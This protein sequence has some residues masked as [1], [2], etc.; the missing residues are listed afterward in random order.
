MGTSAQ[1]TKDKTLAIPKAV[2]FHIRESFRI[3]GCA[4]SP[5]I[6]T[7]KYSWLCFYAHGIQ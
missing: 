6:K 7:T 4:Q 5:G 2:C 3:A 1:V